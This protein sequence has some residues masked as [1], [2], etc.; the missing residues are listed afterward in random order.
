MRMVHPASRHLQINE[1]GE[2]EFHL[3][4]S[5]FLLYFLPPPF[6]S[7]FFSLSLSLFLFL[8]Y[9]EYFCSMYISSIKSSNPRGETDSRVND[10]SKFNL[11]EYFIFC[12]ATRK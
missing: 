10:Y 5:F 3:F 12:A 9:S 6:L 11:T 7:L 2:F 1:L 4:L 8:F